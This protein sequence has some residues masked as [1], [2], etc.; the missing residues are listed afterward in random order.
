MAARSEKLGFFPEHLRIDAGPIQV[1]PLPELRSIVDESSSWEGVENGWIY[2]PPRPK[3][4]FLSGQVREPPYSARVFGLPK[5]HVIEHRQATDEDHLCFLVWV[6]SF[7][8]GMRLTTEEAGFLD[9]TPIRQGMLV[10]F[11]LVGQ[12]LSRALELADSFW[13]GN[14]RKPKNASRFAA[15]VH[16]LFLGQN[17]QALQ[18][19]RFLYLYTALD[20]CYSL[21][22]AIG[23]SKG[24]CLTQAGSSGHVTN[25]DSTCPPGPTRPI[26]E[27]QATPEWLRSGTTRCTRPSLW[28]NPWVSRYTGFAPPRGS[29]YRSTLR[30]ETSSAVS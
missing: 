6:L 13:R 12:S 5:T 2:A 30:C 14:L 15:A 16:A 26:V 10:D 28:V 11:A 25:S 22:A 17:P 8:V 18:Y 20:A 23:K 21:A 27:A 29:K 3:R 19:E 1:R 24:Q 9:A 4:D 7:F